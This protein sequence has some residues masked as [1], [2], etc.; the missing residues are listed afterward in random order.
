M[1][2]GFCFS[3][4]GIFWC[5]GVGFWLECLCSFYALGF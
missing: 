2:V 4:L 1:V 5:L 3:S